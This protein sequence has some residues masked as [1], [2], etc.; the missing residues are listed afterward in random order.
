MSEAP[1]IVD[2]ARQ[3]FKTHFGRNSAFRLGDA[4][5]PFANGLGSLAG[6]ASPPRSAVSRREPLG[7]RDNRGMARASRFT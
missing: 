2:K 6:R 7:R 5:R 3:G 1:R 4:S